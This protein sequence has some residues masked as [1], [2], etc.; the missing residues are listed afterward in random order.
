MIMAGM[1]G[2]VVSSQNLGAASG[3]GGIYRYDI[4]SP[5][6]T[7][8]TTDTAND[9]IT[10]TLND[11]SIALVTVETG[12]KYAN[13]IFPAIVA[14]K[15]RDFILRLTIVSDTIPTITF[16]EPNGNPVSFDVMD[17]DWADVEQGVNIFSFTDTST[18][19]V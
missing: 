7:Y 14:Q 2:S 5:V 3:G 9:T 19:S 13:F 6:L 15:S 1:M 10:A 16:S 18:E 12:I 4:Y 11:H 8:S 17:E